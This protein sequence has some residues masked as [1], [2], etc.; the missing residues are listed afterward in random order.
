MNLTYALAAIAIIMFALAVPLHAQGG[1]AD[2]PEDPT[3]AL[4]LV[5]SVGAGIAYMRTRMKAGS[6]R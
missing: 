1:C 5:A 4:A 6:K 3:V 2:S